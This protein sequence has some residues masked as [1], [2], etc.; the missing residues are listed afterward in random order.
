[1]SNDVDPNKLVELIPTDAIIKVD[2]SGAFYVRLQQLLITYAQQEKD[3]MVRLKE[4]ETR[5]PNDAFEYNIITL[6]TLTRSVERAAEEQKQ[7]VT[8]TVSEL[9]AN[10]ESQ[11]GGP[12]N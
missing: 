3:Y 2:F 9:L 12:E 11:E 6:L 8:K 10:Q 5:E 1:M 7:V 4:L